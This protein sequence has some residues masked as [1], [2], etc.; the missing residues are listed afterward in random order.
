MNKLRPYLFWIVAGVVLLIELGVVLMVSPTDTGGRSA[1][2]VKADIDTRYGDLVKLSAR[3]DGPKGNP[4][5]IGPFNPEMAEHIKSLTGDYLVTQYWEPVLKPHVEK[6]GAQLKEIT[7]YLVKRSKVL[8]D[9]V[10]QSGDLFQWYQSYEARTSSVVAALLEAHCLQ[11]PISGAVSAVADSE[12]V[13]KAS[14]DVAGFYTK[15]EAPPAASEHERLT[16]R[17]RVVDQIAQIVLAAR[18]PNRA[19]AVTGRPEVPVPDGEQRQAAITAIKW[20]ETMSG[21]MPSDGLALVK[22]TVELSGPLSAVLATQSALENNA[23]E[24]RPLF[25]MLGGTLLPKTPYGVGERK[26]VPSETVTAKLDLVALDYSSKTY[27]PPAPLV[28]VRPAPAKNVARNAADAAKD[29][30]EGAAP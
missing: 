26:D 1:T 7:A 5:P 30:K 6:Y 20:D 9:P 21:S 22:V 19:N 27:E 18:Q 11:V 8:H 28:K 17:Y 29:E 3:A 13:T 24:E 4:D 12:T 23:D 16:L 15:G 2:E 25:V 10:A 14:R